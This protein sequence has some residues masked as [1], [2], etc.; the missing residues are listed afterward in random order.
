MFTPCDTPTNEGQQSARLKSPRSSEG[1]GM[2]KEL[3]QPC[4]NPLLYGKQSAA[5]ATQCSV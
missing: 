1:S 3:L 2:T 5:A 4:R